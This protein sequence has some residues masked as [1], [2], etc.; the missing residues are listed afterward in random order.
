MSFVH[1]FVGMHHIICWSFVLKVQKLTCYVCF[2]FHIKNIQLCNNLATIFPILWTLKTEINILY[3]GKLGGHCFKSLNREALL[4]MFFNILRALLLNWKWRYRSS[5]I[6]C[7]YKGQ[8]DII[9]IIII[10]IICDV[11]KQNQSEV[12]NIHLKIESN[13]AENVFCFLLFLASFNCSYLWNQLTNF[14]GVFCK[15]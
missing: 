3:Q 11:I 7:P 2:C 15:M 1:C 5:C 4:D 9:I 10:I 6:K 14:N 13:K 8:V 12:W